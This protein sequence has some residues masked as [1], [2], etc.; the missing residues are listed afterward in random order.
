MK[1]PLRLEALPLVLAASCLVACGSPGRSRQ[2]SSRAL[3]S[4][5]GPTSHQ[6]TLRWICFCVPDFTRPTRITVRDGAIASATDEET[7]MAV[8]PSTRRLL[9]IDGLFDVIDDAYQR[10]AAQ[11]DVTYDPND[12]HPVSA[13]IDYD[14]N[15]VDEELGFRVLDLQRL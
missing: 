8:D 12:G 15:A 4:E 9:T 14:K 5:E 11:V 2:E 6:F 10:N 3:W 7:G 13:N 1:N